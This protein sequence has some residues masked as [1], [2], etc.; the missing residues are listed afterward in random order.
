MLAD[1]SYEIY[2][3]IPSAK[4]DGFIDK[5]KFKIRRCFRKVTIICVFTDRYDLD[6]FILAS[7]NKICNKLIRIDDSESKMKNID[8]LM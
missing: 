6:E 8:I 7:Y 4:Y 2:F 3:A 1:L 5:E